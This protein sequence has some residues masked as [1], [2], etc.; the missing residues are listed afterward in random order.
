MHV[1]VP[2]V[3]IDKLASEKLGEK[4]DDIRRRVEKAREIQQKRFSASRGKDNNIVTNAEMS[5][6]Q[7]KEFCQIDEKSAQLLRQAVTQLNLSARSYF[8][9]L[10]LS[11]TIADLAGEENIKLDHVAEALQYRPKVE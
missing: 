7:T 6:R 5:S 9:I 11:R 1:E 8:R 10:K 3:K 2:K 4:S